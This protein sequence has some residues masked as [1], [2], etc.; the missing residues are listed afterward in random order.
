MSLSSAADVVL[1]YGGRRILDGL[2]LT[3]ETGD[4]YAVTGRSGSGKTTLLLVMAGLLPPTSGRATLGVPSREISYVPQTPSLIPELSAL[5]NAALGLRFRGIAPGQAAEQA[6]EALVLLGL[7]DATDALPSE[8]S[9]G[10]QQRVAIA[11][12][13]VLAPRLLLADEP[14][15]TLDR[16]AG[17]QVLAV[18]RD[19][20]TRHETALLVATHDPEIA[21]LF[22]HQLALADGRVVA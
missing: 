5:D 17:A 19:L 22:P 9:G 11:R 21:A 13:V 4:Q 14:T 3:I 16:S 20:A 6:R 12:A 10:M 2:D 18:L 7:G 15:G 8:L 1:E